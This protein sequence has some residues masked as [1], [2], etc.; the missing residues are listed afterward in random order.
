MFSLNRELAY[1]I[2]VYLGD[3]NVSIYQRKDG[4]G[5]NYLFRHASIDE[6]FIEETKRCL[7]VILPE[8][9][10][11]IY[12][13]KPQNFRFRNPKLQYELHFTDKNLCEFLIGITCNKQKIPEFLEDASRE[14]RLSFLAGFLDSEGWVQKSK[15]K[16]SRYGGQI[17]VGFCGT[18]QWIDDIAK[19]FQRIGVRLGKRQIQLPRDSG[20]IKSRLPKIRYILQTNSF[21]KSG[22]YFTIQRK[23]SRLR[24]Y[25]ITSQYRKE[26]LNEFERFE[27]MIKDDPAISLR[28]IQKMWGVNRETARLWK[29]KIK[30]NEPLFKIEM[31]G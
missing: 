26:K 24:D 9:K 11:R 8:R 21:I 25:N 5:K 1:L 4:K 14:I 18:S 30:H 22:C 20:I 19:M 3:G 6:D 23:Q 16:D 12:E 31:K 15:R 7:N 2:G 17:Q 27:E 28:R 29:W 13:K 10:C